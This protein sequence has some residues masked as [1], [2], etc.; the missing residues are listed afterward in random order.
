MVMAKDNAKK[1]LLIHEELR[2][3][4]TQTNLI[5]ETLSKMQGSM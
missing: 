1:M 5:L 3:S 2:A 4:N